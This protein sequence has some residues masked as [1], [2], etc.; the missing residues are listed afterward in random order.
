MQFNNILLIV[1]NKELILLSPDSSEEQA[2]AQL[3]SPIT[4]NW[5]CS[6]RPA[7]TAA[8]PLDGSTCPSQ[9]QEQRSTSTETHG[10]THSTDQAGLDKE[11]SPASATSD[12]SNLQLCVSVYTKEML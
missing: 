2:G 6:Q 8:A 11:R 10:M 9:V 12:S 3:A 4:L 1:I 7:G 5:E